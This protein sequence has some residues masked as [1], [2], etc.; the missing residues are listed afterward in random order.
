MSNCYPDNRSGRPTMKHVAKLA[1]VGIKTVSRVINNEPGVTEGTQERVLRAVAQ[2]KYQLD[3]NAGNLRRS[4]R[5]T[6][7]LGL[8]LPSVANQLSGE[9]HRAVEDA[10]APRGI[11]IFTSSVDDELEGEQRTVVALL[12]RRVDGLI[13]MPS[14]QD[15][16]YLGSALEYELPLVFVGSEPT[17]I[18]ADSITSDNRQGAAAGA[19]HLI[20]H[21][22]RRMAYLGYA[23]SI[24][25]A[26]ERRRG[27]TD[28]AAR[29][30]ISEDRLIV[31]ELHDLN[32]A[33]AEAVRLLTGEAPPTAI[34]SSHVLVTLGVLRALKELRLQHRVALV[35]FDDFELAD[36]LD[37][38][39]TV[40]AQHPEQIGRLAAERVLARLDGQKLLPERIVV[41][42]TLIPRGSGEIRPA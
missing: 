20:H 28:E 8:V 34:F 42:S 3:V 6:R 31:Q 37:P 7:T 38:G 27:F 19:A 4:D 25:T 35:G 12:Q 24:H 17:G 29:A 41:P 21:G 30:G 23:S 22:H 2:L 26:S 36:L 33:Q 5:R 9:I 16:S 14:S 18:M 10:M 13:I 40:V 11:A 15:Q 1:G 32:A 39:V